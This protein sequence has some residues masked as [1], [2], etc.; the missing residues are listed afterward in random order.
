[1]GRVKGLILI[2]GTTGIARFDEE[3]VAAIVA[4]ERNQQ[5]RRTAMKFFNMAYD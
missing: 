4:G 5:L 3:E 1:M 2:A